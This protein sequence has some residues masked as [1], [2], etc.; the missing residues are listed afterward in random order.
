MRTSLTSWCNN[1]CSNIEWYKEGAQVLHQMVHAGLEIINVRSNLTLSESNSL[2]THLR[3]IVN[4][5][6]R[7]TIESSSTSYGDDLAVWLVLLAAFV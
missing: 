7:E 3:C 2:L 6:V 4:E 1:I 5:W